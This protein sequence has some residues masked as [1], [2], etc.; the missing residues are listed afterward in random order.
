MSVLHKDDR[1]HPGSEHL[2]DTKYNLPAVM[3][4]CFHHELCVAVRLKKTQDALSHL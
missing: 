2:L 4:A 3:D 1:S